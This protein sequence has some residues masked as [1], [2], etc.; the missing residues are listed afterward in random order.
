MGADSLERCSWIPVSTHWPRFTPSVSFCAPPSPA[1]LPLS[2]HHFPLSGAS[3]LDGTC[4]FPLTLSLLPV[5]LR[6]D[7]QLANISIQPWLDVTN[8]AKWHWISTLPTCQVWLIWKYNECLLLLCAIHELCVPAFV[9]PDEMGDWVDDTDMMFDWDY[10]IA[11]RGDSVS[12]PAVI[13][14][15]L[16]IFFGY[17]IQRCPKYNVECG[18]PYHSVI[19]KMILNNT[20]IMFAVEGNLLL[21]Y[22]GRVSDT[23]HSSPNQYL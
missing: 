16:A 5:T 22:I 21:V 13:F 18:V 1:L 12:V 23:A 6:F 17:L 14:G 20:C 2:S 3:F 7:S 15:C 8:W 10:L 4:H 11:W 19:Q 9:D